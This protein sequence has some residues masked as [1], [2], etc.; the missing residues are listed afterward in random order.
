[1]I[2]GAK[3]EE[4]RRG[5]LVGSLEKMEDIF[6][7]YCNRGDE[8]ENFIRYMMFR[9][10]RGLEGHDWTNLCFR[11]SGGEGDFHGSTVDVYRLDPREEG[12][13]LKIWALEWSPYGCGADT[14]TMISEKFDLPY[15]I[16]SIGTDIQ[17]SKEDNRF[18]F[19]FNRIVAGL[20][21]ALGEDI[22]RI[23]DIEGEELLRKFTVVKKHDH[24]MVFFKGPEYTASMTL[25][26]VAGPYADCGEVFLWE[27]DGPIL[28]GPMYGT[29]PEPLQDRWRLKAHE[30]DEYY[31]SV[32]I[33]IMGSRMHKFGRLPMFDEAHKKKARLL[34]ERVAVAFTGKSGPISIVGSN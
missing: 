13:Y 16:F 7:F 10:R 27:A 26:W 30:V 28:T 3:Q 17:Y 18:S 24:T 34:A 21:E 33:D 9:I 29:L 11:Y 25:H 2:I 19:D 20:Q 14:A 1:L 5:V 31:P 23:M 15:G 8:E 22:P 12:F 6:R 32:S 4:G